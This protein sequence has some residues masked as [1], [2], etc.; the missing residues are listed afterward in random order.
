M[1]SRVHPKYKTQYRVGNWPAY[2][3]VL[4]QRGDITM[5]LAPDAIATWEGS[6][7]LA[8]AGDDEGERGKGSGCRHRVP[9]TERSGSE[10]SIVNRL[11]LV[12]PDSKQILHNAVDVQ[13]PLRVG[14]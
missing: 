9:H 5:W 2:D 8:S 6:A 4:V 14:G 12:S 1:Q 13:E 7:N 3:R 11:Q 10:P